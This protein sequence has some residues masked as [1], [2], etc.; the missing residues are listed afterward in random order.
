MRKYIMSFVMCIA[1]LLILAAC[2]CGSSDEV[3]QEF[4]PPGSAPPLMPNVDSLASRVTD[5]VRVEVLDRRVER[6]LST[7]PSPYDYIFSRISTIHRMRVLEIFQGDTE[8]GDIIDVM[9]DGGRLGN[10]ELVCNWLQLFDYGDE[11]VI[12]I[13]RSDN[14]ESQCMWFPARGQG[15]YRI[16]LSNARDASE[17]VDGIAAAYNSNPELGSMIL[18]SLTPS[19]LCEIELTVGDLILIRYEAGLGPRPHNLQLPVGVDRNRLNESIARAEYYLLQNYMLPGW[20]RVQELL[21]IAISVRDNPYSRQI[22]VNPASRRLRDEMNFLGIDTYAP[23]PTPVPPT[24]TSA[25]PPL[26][27]LID[28]HYTH[29]FT[30]NTGWPIFEWSITGKIPGMTFDSETGTLSGTPDTQGEFTLTITLANA[31]GYDSRTFTL[32]IS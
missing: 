15:V 18:E 10:A 23:V 6:I 21:E 1:F 11:L 22:H 29:T 5:I 17:F 30:G 27:L 32:V 3:R 31:A 9:Q 13:G 19:T 12:F 24:I 20:D 28:T 2:S 25:N 14:P 7:K 8:T 4:L 26:G 16:D